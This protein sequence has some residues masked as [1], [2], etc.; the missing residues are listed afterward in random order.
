[1]KSFLSIL[2]FQMLCFVAFAQ[3]PQM[4][5]READG[6]EKPLRIEQA[7]V[8]VQMLGD[9]AET[10]FELTF[11]N[12]G[13]RAVEGEF[14]LTLPEGATVSDYALEVNGAMRAAV[15]VEKERART[16][17]ETVKR[18]LIDPG[19]VEREA[20]NV[21]RTKVYPVPAEGTKKLRIRYIETLRE[22]GDG[23]LF[24][25]PL[26]FSEPVDRF[27]CQLVGEELR[28]T[29]GAGLDFADGGLRADKTSFRPTGRLEV[30]RK[31]TEEELMVVE[32]GPKPAF[33]LSARI[34]EMAPRA[35]PAP[36]TVMLVWD[37]SGSGRGRDYAT[38]FALLD[39]WFTQLG[40]TRVKLCLLRDQTEDA[41][42]FHVRGGAWQELKQALEQVDYDGATDFSQLTVASGQADVMLLVSDGISTLGL[43][44]PAVEVP[45]FFLHPDSIP[46]GNPLGRLAIASGGDDISLS[47]KF[48]TAALDKLSLAMPRLIAVTGVDVTDV[49]I[50]ATPGQRLRVL[51]TL[52]ESREGTLDIRYGCGNEVVTTRTVSYQPGGNANGM[53]RRL[54]AQRV[55]ADIER[56][57]PPDRK[58]II[59]H[60][61]RHCLVSEFTSLIVLERLE[62]Y[63]EHGIRPPEPELQSQYD[64][65]SRKFSK[66]TLERIDGLGR[67]WGEK[68]AW[69]AKRFPGYEARILPRLRQVGIWKQAVESQFA[70]AQRDAPA[71]GVIAGWFDQGMELVDRIPKI[72]T[73]EEYDD[74]RKG[75]DGLHAQGQQLAT[76]PLHAPPAGQELAVSVRGLVAKPGVIT[77]KRPLTLREAVT[78]AGKHRMG[79]LD[80][81]A[82]Y[83]NAGKVVYN[84]LSERFQDVPLFPAD[85]VVIGQRILP[86]HSWDPFCESGPPPDPRNEAPIRDE[87]DVWTSQAAAV[88]GGGGRGAQVHGNGGIRIIPQEVDSMELPDP[89]VF[90]NE[91]TAGKNPESVYQNHR[92]EGEL[93]SKF[94]I[95]AARVLFSQNHDALATRVLSNLVEMRP[96]DVSALRGYA[97]WLAEF[98]QVDLAE[99]VLV[100]I[101][102]DS[103]TEM[104]VEMDLA[105]LRS[106]RGNLEEA[107]SGF[108]E[109]FDVEDL[110]EFPSGELAAIALAEFN[111]LNWRSD[112]RLA[113]GAMVWFGEQYDTHL[114]ADIRIVLTSSDD[115][116]ALRFEMIE[117]GGFACSNAASPSPTGG[118]VAA[119]SGVR[120]YMI[121]HAV[122]GTYE[123]RCGSDTP[124]TVRAVI[125]TNWGRPN[126]TTRVV[127]VML[128]SDKLIR[129]AELEFEF[130]AA[131]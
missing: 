103:R 15:A 128:S 101:S 52:K 90:E 129:I 83:R 16:A 1:M 119:S 118:R 122:P 48:T 14:A 105:S 130:R 97:F 65:L 125:H 70:P 58:A 69:Y 36:E 94:Y 121:R 6:S 111:G 86:D 50:E 75:I 25:L 66:R 78:M 29:D 39:A 89:A 38:E 77:S 85:M 34:P 120:E 9:V 21:Y 71:F 61:K 56:Q 37:A 96:G 76:T 19:I 112:L 124:I 42:E 11:C 17:Y 63:A 73:A 115:A 28:I 51:G 108:Y 44:Q 109:T 92:G 114:P 59:A 64:E 35:R 131:E 100:G 49:V 5:V 126:E 91:L 107:V 95:E 55:L 79:S 10:V 32:D 82:L 80:H 60:C 102:G 72:R 84:T 54:Q 13:P 4:T 40:D 7:D 12:D 113:P 93:S 46:A 20:G 8:S 45:W 18:R 33:M 41:G 24:S 99:K 47:K 98:G 106:V 26:N 87:T 104:L 116:D 68:L 81:V 117:P 110:A 30:T 123:I 27:S 74:W 53:V 23:F 2:L 3:S 43:K 31:P 22:G 57:F 67:I 127:T 88:G 62:D